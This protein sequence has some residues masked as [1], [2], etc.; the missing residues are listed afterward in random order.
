MDHVAIWCGLIR[1]IY[2]NRI[3]YRYLTPLVELLEYGIA[4]G[5]ERVV[6][7]Y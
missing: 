4:L 5:E 6:I 3:L 2:K 1:H 7:I